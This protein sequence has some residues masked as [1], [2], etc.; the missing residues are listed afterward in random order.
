MCVCVCVAF[1]GFQRIRYHF[2]TP[3]FKLLSISKIHHCST[4]A[5]LF[6]LKWKLWTLR[7][8]PSEWRSFIRHSGLRAGMTWRSVQNWCKRQKRSDGSSMSLAYAADLG[9][10]YFPEYLTTG[11]CA[12]NNVLGKE[13]AI[14]ALLKSS[15]A[16]ISNQHWLNDAYSSSCNAYTVNSDSGFLWTIPLCLFQIGL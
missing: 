9:Y 11:T 15:P 16:W 4:I 8:T 6:L 1:C 2:L 14:L 5:S 13:G 7:A 3:F 10:G 12:D